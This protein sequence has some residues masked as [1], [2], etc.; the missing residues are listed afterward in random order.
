MTKHYACYEYYHIYYCYEYYHIY[1][2]YLDLLL[3]QGP[4]RGKVEFICAEKRARI[5]EI[6]SYAKL[7]SV[8]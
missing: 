7:L 5:L 6:L 4:D 2:Y 1:Y 8:L 3:H